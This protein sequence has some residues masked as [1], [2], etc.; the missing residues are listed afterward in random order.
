ML[1]GLSC[2]VHG[3]DN[4]TGAGAAGASTLILL[5][6]LVWSVALLAGFA[7]VYQDTQHPCDVAFQLFFYATPIIYDRNDLG[8]GH[9]G[10]VTHAVPLGPFLHLIR[11]P[12]LYEVGSPLE[13]Y[14][15]GVLG[16]QVNAG[17]GGLRPGR[18][19]FALQL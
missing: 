19:R 15:R 11:E 2:Y 10:L 14:A 8:P 13:A 17:G 1:V 4:F 12:I 7:N 18:R 5:F 6:A 3:A 16:G 9:G